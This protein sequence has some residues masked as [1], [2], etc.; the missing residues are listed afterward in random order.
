MGSVL[1]S[2][3]SIQESIERIAKQTGTEHLFGDIGKVLGL[4]EKKKSVEKGKTTTPANESKEVD[5]PKTQNSKS[6]QDTI[7]EILAAVNKVAQDSGTEYLLNNI[8][9]VLGNVVS[10][11]KVNENKAELRREIKAICI[12]PGHG[13]NFSGILDKGTST[14][15]GDTTIYEKDIILS[16]AIS[17]KEKLNALGFNVILTRS[18][19]MPSK[20]K[21]FAWRLQKAN[22]ADLFISLHM[23]Y[24]AN[25]S[26]RGLQLL[27][28][29]GEITT[30]NLID[31]KKYD[32]KSELSEFSE[33]TLKKQAKNSRELAEQILDSVTILPDLQRGFLKG[34]THNILRNFEGVASI[35]VEMGVIGN[36]DDRNVLEND[37]DTLADEIAKGVVNYVANYKD[38]K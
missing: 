36:T 35:I 31:N 2:I 20:Q 17:L 11:E 21:R 18:G 13:D 34:E 24:Y 10:R 26:L 37:F 38:D 5:T 14:K 27:Y 7:N 28:F 23:G 16:V 6:V 25:A 9:T 3:R 22:D 30:E 8:G 12:D 33:E 1:D 19:D 4:D 15:L 32:Q 29:S